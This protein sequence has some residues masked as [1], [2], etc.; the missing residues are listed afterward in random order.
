MGGSEQ[1][2]PGY[3]YVMQGRAGWMS[4]TGEP[5]G[6]PEKTGLSLV[7]YSTGLVAAMALISAVYA[8]RRTGKGADCDVALFDTAI[9]MLTYVG[10][11]HL[12]RGYLPAR[13]ASS[14]H[15]SL[16][17]F[18]NFQ[19]SDGWIVVACAKEKFWL[20]LVNAL[21]STELASESKFSNF[22]LRKQYETQLVAELSQHFRQRSTAEWLEILNKAQVPYGQINDVVMD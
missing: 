8:A 18:Q 21:N 13:T 12:S 6:P 1:G 3:D 15:P 14:A 5:E 22:K 2:I 7:D 19:T 4:L 9:G 20:R 11:W 17:P 16:V 10:T